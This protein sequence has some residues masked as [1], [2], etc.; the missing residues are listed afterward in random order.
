MAIYH[1]RVK[2]VQ[3]S[4]GRSA[5]AAAAYRSGERLTDERRGTVEDYTRKQDIEHS[6]VM[7]PEGIPVSLQDRGALW[8]AV[9]TGIKHPR[10]QPAFE[11]E[12]A[13]PRELDKAQCAQLVRE[14]A[15]DHFVAKG[16]P[17]DFAIH[18]TPAS[19]GGEH[20]HAHILVSTRRFNEDGSIGKAARDMQDNPKLVAKVY[21]LEEE[22]KIDEAV[23]LQKDLNLG[24]WR[25]SWEDYSNR[26]LSDAGSSSRI[27]H[28]TLAAQAV[29]GELA[30]EPT[31]NI[32]I[33]FY[34]HLRAFQGHMAERVQHWKEVGFRNAMREQMDRIMERRPDLNAEFIAHAREYA[35]NLFPEIGRD[36]PE[37]EQGLDYEQ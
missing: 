12:V 6:E 36:E 2:F 28:R 4:A 32:G 37:L 15:Q 29:E 31:P 35:R 11:V 30:R 34:G 18:R 25:K 14:F 22:G 10:G 8:N 24:Q 7:L 13:L 27:D 9:E 23:M 16:L 26:F 21:A 1:L 5:V 17:V 19:D 3:R 33:G 20:P